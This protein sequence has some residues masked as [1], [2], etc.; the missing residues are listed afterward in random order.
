[1]TKKQTQPTLTLV[2][3]YEHKRGRNP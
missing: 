2:A 1:V 3:R